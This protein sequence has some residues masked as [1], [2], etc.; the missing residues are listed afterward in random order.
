MNPG[1]IVVRG[2]LD[3]DPTQVGLSK[4]D[5]VVDALPPDRADRRL[6]LLKIPIIVEKTEGAICV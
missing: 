2:E 3:N 4:H 6:S 1:A 5:Q